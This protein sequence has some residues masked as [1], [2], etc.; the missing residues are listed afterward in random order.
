MKAAREGGR[1]VTS[2]SL[3]EGTRRSVRTMGLLAAASV[4][5]GCANDV[6]SQDI[7]AGIV[8]ATQ[9]APGADL[10]GRTTFAIV[11]KV[12][13]VSDDGSAASPVA[14]P[15]LVASVVAN[16]EAR[17][18]V[19]AGEIDPAAPP[20][21]PVVADLAVNLTA[22]E[23]DRAE[24]A[25]W[26]GSPAHTRPS[27]WGYPAYAWAYGWQW[28]PVAPTRGTVIVE[29][30]DLVGAVPGGDPGASPLVVSWA[31]LGYG[32]SPGPSSYDTAALLE[33]VDRAFAQSP[34]LQAG[35]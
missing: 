10:A 12:G 18:F 9:R 28:S 33:A 8:V 20:P 34:Y 14:A 21:A 6:R 24:P 35:P 25:Y 3:R 29:I 2:R 30:A 23:S 19:R 22:L 15:V 5:S 11:T 13:V 16:L 32:V 26:L 31:A 1:V 17:G 4:I 27:A 7:A